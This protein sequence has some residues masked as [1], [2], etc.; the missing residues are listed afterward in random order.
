MAIDPHAGNDRGPQQWEGTAAEGEADNA[1]FRATL[2]ANGVAGRVRHV[3]PPV[4]GGAR[5]RRGPDRRPLR[6]R[7]APLRARSADI[8]RWGARVVPGGTLLIHDAFSS[9]GVTLAILRLLAPGSRFRYV[10]RSGSLAEY[11]RE[12]LAPAARARN[13]AAQLGALPGSRATWWSRRRS[14]RAC[15]RSPARSGTGPGRGR[16][17]RR[18]PAGP[19]SPR[20]PLLDSIRAIAALSV[21]VFHA[22][23]GRG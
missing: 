11:R 17:E 1:A 16:T 20:F 2:A 15:R 4:A 13:A 18:R 6:R 5:R 14:S 22:A 7:R 9:V 8:A 21:V 23:C 12:D 10:G 19:R 3:P